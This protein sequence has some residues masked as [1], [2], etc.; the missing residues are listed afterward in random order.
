VICDILQREVRLLASPVRF[1]Y[2]EFAIIRTFMSI[3]DMDQ[4]KIRLFAKNLIAF[5]GL[6]ITKQQVWISVFMNAQLNA[7][8]SSP[9]E[10]EQ[11]VERVWRR[12]K[13]V[14]L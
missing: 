2:G 3:K 9:S 8:V 5:Y 14:T 12:I 6:S 10:K 1:N 7:C 13:K 4:H 11:I